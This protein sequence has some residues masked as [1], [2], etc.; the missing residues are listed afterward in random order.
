MTLDTRKTNL[1]RSELSI[2]LVFGKVGGITHV[3]TIFCSFLLTKFAALSYRIDAIHAIFEIQTKDESILIKEGF[4]LKIN[5][6]D[7]ICWLTGSFC[8]NKRKQRFVDK[9]QRY[10]SKE[11]DI[12]K[13]KKD[14]IKLK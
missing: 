12:I 6:I 13:M 7:K 3:L 10:L 11:L 4:K 5:L 9:G 14:L 2:L 1:Y 8:Q